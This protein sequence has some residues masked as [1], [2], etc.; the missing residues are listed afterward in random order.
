M[1]FKSNGRTFLIVLWRYSSGSWGYDLCLGK[2][3]DRWVKNWKTFSYLC[4]HCEGETIIAAS[5]TARNIT[6][7]YA[8]KRKQLVSKLQH[9]NFSFRFITLG[10]VSSRSWNVFL[11][12][13]KSG[14]NSLARSCLH[15]SSGTQSVIYFANGYWVFLD[16]TQATR[17]LAK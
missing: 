17:T 4:S 9:S 16:I 3:Y 6:I 8:Q 11:Q 1:K 15:L 5:I 10:C 2:W 7:K 14:A 12:V 13:T